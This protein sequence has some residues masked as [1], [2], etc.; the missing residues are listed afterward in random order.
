[1]LVPLKW[2]PRFLWDSDRSLNKNVTS[3]FYFFD[4]GRDKKQQ[5]TNENLKLRD[6]YIIQNNISTNR[7]ITLQEYIKIII[8]K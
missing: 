4:F 7:E 2:R 6:R 8:M 3:N 5:Q 1:M